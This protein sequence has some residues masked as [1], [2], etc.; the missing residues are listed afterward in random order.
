MED[1]AIRGTKYLDFVKV[2][3]LQNEFG[4]KDC[5]LSYDFSYEKCS[6]IFPEKFSA[7]FSGSEKSR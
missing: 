6:E 4:A 5:F 2:A 7:F 3:L 1:T